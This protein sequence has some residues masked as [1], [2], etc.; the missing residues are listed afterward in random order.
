MTQIAE[1]AGRKVVKVTRAQV[2]AA[3]GKIVT[4]RRQGKDTPEW[5][6]AVAE[7]KPARNH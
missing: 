6:K 7:A 5:V 2:A 4:D 3:K 1:P